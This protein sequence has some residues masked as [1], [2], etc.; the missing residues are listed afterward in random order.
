MRYKILRGGLFRR[1][2]SEH[3]ATDGNRDESMVATID[4]V[5]GSS[6]EISEIT[7]VIERIAFQTD[8]YPMSTRKALPVLA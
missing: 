2:C 8:Q 7:G 1:D 5:N 6:T 4:K 3:D